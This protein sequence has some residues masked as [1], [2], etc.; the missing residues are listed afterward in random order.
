MDFAGNVVS[1][2]HIAFR[3]SGLQ[4]ARRFAGYFQIILAVVKIPSALSTQSY[5]YR[6]ETP[7]R[8]IVVA[9]SR[10]ALPLHA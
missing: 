3:I 7:D 8:V 2:R 10:A 5:S 9:A 6:F 4:I 1:R